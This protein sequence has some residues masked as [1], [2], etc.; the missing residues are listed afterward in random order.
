MS[1]R[2][3]QK[4]RQAAIAANKRHWCVQAPTLAYVRGHTNTPWPNIRMSVGAS[5]VLHILCQKLHPRDEPSF[6]NGCSF[7][8]CGRACKYAKGYIPLAVIG[9]ERTIAPYSGVF[10]RARHNCRGQLTCSRLVCVGAGVT[11]NTTGRKVKHPTSGRMG[12]LL[13]YIFIHHGNI[14]ASCI[15]YATRAHPLLCRHFDRSF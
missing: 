7:C 11:M 6:S 13:L 4:V 14:Q 12:I 2:T 9:A 5:L 10:A 1:F 3:E 8:A 15:Q